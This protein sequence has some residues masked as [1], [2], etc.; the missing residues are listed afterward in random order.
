LVSRP[1]G[2]NSDSKFV[3]HNYVVSNAT[4]IGDPKATV[5]SYGKQ[6]DG[7]TGPVDGRTEGMS[8]GTSERDAAHWRSLGGDAKGPA[9]TTKISA[10]D[11]KVVSA[12]TSVRTSAPYA[13]VPGLTSNGTNSNSVASAVADKAQGSEV[14]LPSAEGRM[15]PGAVQRD[16]V[17][18]KNQ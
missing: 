6:N 8:K 10:D 2:E 14:K 17:E 13:V 12:A 7:K 18:F 4:R 16:R 11:A 3:A 5:C 15:A 9:M 1:L